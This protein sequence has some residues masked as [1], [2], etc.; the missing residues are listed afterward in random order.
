M[1]R[2]FMLIIARLKKN[3]TTDYMAEQL[4]ITRSQY[5]SI[6]NGHTQ[7]L[8]K[9][10]LQKMS[11]LLD[12]PIE[13][14]ELTEDKIVI[15]DSIGVL[16]GGENN[17]QTNHFANEQLMKVIEQQQATLEQQQKTIQ[18]QQELI[19]QFLDKKD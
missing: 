8:K 1:K 10:H 17:T 3:Y 19:R 6:E 13:I 2:R 18:Q 12:I 7:I 5:S 11:E 14:I 4:G 15:K 16:Y 9:Q